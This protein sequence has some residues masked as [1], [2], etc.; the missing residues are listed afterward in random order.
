MRIEPKLIYSGYMHDLY[1]IILRCHV[2]A[3]QTVLHSPCVTSTDRL[4][5]NEQRISISGTMTT[6]KL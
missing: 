2:A 6:Q 4:T 1:F 5:F 3:R